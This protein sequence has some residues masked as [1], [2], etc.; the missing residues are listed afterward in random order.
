MNVRELCNQIHAVYEKIVK[1]T[2]ITLANFAS[3]DMKPQQIVITV[4]GKLANLL[5]G[6]KSIDLTKVKCIV[7]D[8]ADVFFTDD[9]NF[10]VLKKLHS[11]K[12]V[13]EAKPQWIFFSATYPSNENEKIQKKMSDI[14]T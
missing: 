6:R 8:E 12:N 4:H 11:Y 1:G 9:K 3:E 2:G 14:I 13:V 5:E 7:V 10:D